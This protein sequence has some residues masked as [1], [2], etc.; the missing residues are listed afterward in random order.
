MPSAASGTSVAAVVA[1]SNQ[2]ASRATKMIR[3]L[4]LD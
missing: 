3:R 4:H 2:E 1:M